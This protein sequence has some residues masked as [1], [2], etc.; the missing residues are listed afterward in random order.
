MAI[1]V[2]L[3]S[4]ILVTNPA[5][6]EGETSNSILQALQ[7]WSGYLEAMGHVKDS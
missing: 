6:R 5:R 4:E 7:E 1:A 3:C 2:C